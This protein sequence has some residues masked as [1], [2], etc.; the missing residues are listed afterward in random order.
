MIH[1]VKRYLAAVLSLAMVL[2]LLPPVEAKAEEI[3][4][5]TNISVSKVVVS[6]AQTDI[7]GGVLVATNNCGTSGNNSAAAL[8]TGETGSSQ[9]GNLGSARVAGM[10]FALPTAAKID[11][12]AITKAE[13]T[14]TVTG[15]NKNL[16]E[17]FTKAGLFQVDPSYYDGMKS[18]TSDNAA[19]TYPAAGNQ[20]D[21]ASTVYSNEQIAADNL[22]KKTFDVTDWVKA[23]IKNNDSYAIF[24]IQTVLSGF[25]MQNEGSDAP[26]L[27]ITV[28]EETDP[29]QAA[30]D[31]LTIPTTLKHDITLPA[32]GL[33]GTVITWKS[34][35]PSV[36]TD[37]GVI[38]RAETNKTATLTATIAKADVT[39]DE[40]NS[41]T[42]DFT[43]TVV[44]K[45]TGNL[46]ASYQ[47]AADDSTV[48]AKDI[49]GNGY[50]GTVKGNGAVVENGLLTLP[51]GEAGSDAAYVELPG[52]LFEEEDT[53][54]ITTWLK[55]EI[56][57]GDYAAMFFG[58]KT[59]YVDADS[60]ATMPVNYWLLNP[61][62]DGCFKSVWTD[63]DNASK[64]YNT[65]TVESGEWTSDEWSLYTTVITPTSITGYYNGVE[66]CSDEKTKTTT[67]FGTD[68]TA[69]IGRS[70]YNDAF[71][72]G[73][74]YGV[75]VYDK[76]LSE[77]EIWSEYYNNFPSAVTVN[78]LYNRTKT[79]VEKLMLGDNDSTD[80]VISPLTFTTQKNQIDLTWKSSDTTVINDEG[81]NVYTGADAKK[82]TITLTG[83]YKGTE[84]FK[85]D[86]EITVESALRE[87]AESLESITIPN[88]DAIRG[89]I[90]LPATAPYGTP[91][92]WES[93]H[94]EIID[95][96]E[97]ANEG[98]DS[99]PAGVV[100]RPAEKTDVKLT[101]SIES[102]AD[103]KK[104]ITVTVLPKAQEVKETDLTDYM[105]AYFVGDGAGQ[106][107]IYFATSRDGLNW[108]EINDAQPMLESTLGEKGVRDPYILRS[109]EGDK[110]YL[111]AT[112]LCI[113]AGKGWSAAQTAGSQAIMVWESTDLVNWSDQRMVTVSADLDAGC[114]WAPEAYYDDKTG[115]YIL[116]WASKVED[117]DYSK[118]RIYYAKT[119]DFYSFTEPEVWIDMDGI[120]TI[121]TTVVRDDDGTYYRFT[122]NE[123]GDQK[124]IFMEK[125]KS[126]LGEWTPVES[127]SLYNEQ[128]VE[129][130]CCFRF[131]SDD[132]ENAK[133][134]WCLLLD[135]F[136]AG[137]YYP[138][139]TSNLNADNVEFT[140]LDAN[141]PS[142]QIPR[143]GTVMPI[144]TAEY[145][146]LMDRYGTA[147]INDDSIPDY[148]K[149]GY[150]LPSKVKVTMA[151]ETNEADVTWTTTNDAFKKTG[152]VTVEGTIPSLN[153]RTVKKTVEVVAPDLIYFIDSGV[154]SW[155]KDRPESGDYNKVSKVDGVTLR[156]TVPDQEYD[157]TK[158][159]WGIVGVD[160]AVGNRTSATDSIY[161]NGWW[162]K[163]NQDCE[164]VLPLESGTYEATGYFSEWWWSAGSF[165]R[166]N[167]YATYTNDSG[168]TVKSELVTADVDASANVKAVLTFD[169]RNVADATEV[170]LISTKS[171]SADPVIAGLAVRKLA[172]GAAVEAARKEAVTAIDSITVTPASKTLYTGDTEKITINYP[173]GLDEKLA[174][175]KMSVASIKYRSSRSATASVASNGTITAKAAGTATIT[176]TITYDDGNKK[177]LKSEITVETKQAVDP[178]PTPTPTPDPS[179]DQTTDRNQNGNGDQNAN[180]NQNTNGTQNETPA[181]E[182]TI[183]L[184]KKSL[185]LGVKEKYNLKA[186]VEGAAKGQAV[187]YSTSKSSVATV[188]ANGKVTA[189]KKGT[190]TI[191]AKTADGKTA[192]C[193]ITVKA[194]P[195][196][197]II[198]KTKLTVKK[199]NRVK[200][201][202]QLPKNT[203]SNKITFT[204]SNKKV[205]KVD[206]TGKV[207]GVKAGKAKITV[208]TFNG[209]K[210]VVTVTVKK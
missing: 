150:E 145:Q 154:G 120:S 8:V 164:Y 207:T 32:A 30:A 188:S 175:A 197:V 149:T 160:S 95:V 103:I 20:Y 17:R 1:R 31:A 134:Q 174:A 39:P 101:A 35:D 158:G 121:D 74:V 153:N 201:K 209:K 152:T 3:G 38:T 6:G 63:G 144:T 184:D 187:T 102:I 75:K 178:T 133:A 33:H 14:I 194:A 110:F 123:N 54:T 140:K 51:G 119:R 141:L 163:T 139:V 156:N 127:T 81:K 22:G 206:T 5:T 46:I 205:A 2:T 198:K 82:I 16:G 83:S 40:D 68:L 90:T 92:K 148:V 189:K 109:A 118:Q 157:G 181:A 72:K 59:K 67:D 169:V 170:H 161:T 12:D 52:D 192:T 117:D 7:K 85:D 66:V 11:A 18:D 70:S 78:D 99:T 173:E 89:N 193:K 204:S 106:E 60:S 25:I 113:G 36:V 37:A 128:W 77:D 24:R 190:A 56:D 4:K 21:Y 172:D 84:V 91:I 130:P 142:K 122:K 166:M 26:S 104:E 203:A 76:A 105:M 131:N 61:S 41:V 171:G 159:N 168:K 146:A 34:D 9:E 155:N 57:D 29:V 138:I 124:R 165:R 49:S 73:G 71:Y 45:Y 162:A 179:G 115:E 126:M 50:D 185:T 53:L 65:E 195:K 96:T 136:G 13:L 87:D 199:G 62:K 100:T 132:R 137:G 10:A 58:T 151:G 108:E 93:D 19:S 42:K 111:I 210:K 28:T 69:F 88:A 23:A 129:G 79:E 182:T 116:F 86:I 15:V 196:K 177:E 186:T 125:S 27:A 143:H 94:P 180:G 191:T 97:K 112:D 183:R 202:V 167:F 55:D 200:I 64:P 43:V 98:Y 47:F 44:K 176:T 80:N 208:K 135:N 147:T 107:K 48:T 114:T